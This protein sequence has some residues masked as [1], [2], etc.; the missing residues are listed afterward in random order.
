MEY[1]NHIL[2]KHHHDCLSLHHH[3]KNPCD[4]P[5]K[6]ISIDLHRHKL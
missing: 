1:H 2:D 4:N 3:R 5:D 6:Y